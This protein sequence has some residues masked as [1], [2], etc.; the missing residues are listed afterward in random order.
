MKFSSLTSTDLERAYKN[1][2]PAI[3]WGNAL[4]GE[5]RHDLDRYY[6]INLSRAF[7]K[8]LKTTRKFTIIS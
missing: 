3:D 6:G 8:A 5:K 7:I 2:Q 1:I 4:A